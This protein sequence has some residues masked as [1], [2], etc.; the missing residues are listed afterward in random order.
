MT[1]ANCGKG[2]FNI[3][4]VMGTS[5]YEVVMYAEEHEEWVQVSKPMPKGAAAC[6]ALTLNKELQQVNDVDYVALCA[7][8]DPLDRM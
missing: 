7:A 8:A 4:D 2:P 5:F 6:L 1:Q 3:R